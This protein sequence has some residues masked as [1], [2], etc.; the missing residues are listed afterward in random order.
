MNSEE[1][2]GKYVTNVY[3]KIATHFD[4]TRQNR[5]PQVVEFINNLSEGNLIGDI[6]CGNGRF[7]LTRKDCEF[8][9][10]DR[11]QAMV[12]ICQKQ[13]LK[14]KQGDV[15]KIP[16]PDDYFDGLV[17]IAVLHHLVTEERRKQ[18]IKEL[19]RIVK[20]GGK[21][22]IEVWSYEASIGSK[23]KFQTIEKENFNEQDKFLSWSE[24]NKPEIKNNP[25]RYYHLF[26]EEEIKELVLENKVELVHCFID[27]GNW[28]LKFIKK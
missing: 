3:N 20:P 25:L 10:C 5:W 21:I 14:V 24:P 12:D 28:F 18:A 8:E 27:H 26:K 22:L 15:T 16:F 6:G 19:I 11:T 7:M 13:G 17:C 23:F 9:G 4:R 2:E 1:F